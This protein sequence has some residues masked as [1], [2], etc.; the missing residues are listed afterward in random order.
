MIKKNMLLLLLL[1]SAQ[2][3][4]IMAETTSDETA[5]VVVAAESLSQVPVDADA[6]LTVDTTTPAPAIETTP[7]SEKKP[8][9]TLPTIDAAW[10]RTLQRSTLLFVAHNAL[11]KTYATV[12][13]K[14][15]ELPTLSEH[16]EATWKN[17]KNSLLRFL[18]DYLYIVAKYMID[19]KYEKTTDAT[20]NEIVEFIASEMVVV[21]EYELKKS[22]PTITDIA[23]NLRGGDADQV[24]FANIR[25]WFAEKETFKAKEFKLAPI[26][27]KALSRKQLWLPAELEITEFLKT[28][29]VRLVTTCGEKGV[30]TGDIQAAK[31]AAIGIG[32]E[33]VANDLLF[34]LAAR[35]QLPKFVV[36]LMATD[37]GF[38][39][40]RDLF[41]KALEDF[42]NKVIADIILA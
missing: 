24:T 14:I 26:F 17:K 19:T 33:K 1:V 22:T 41:A 42:A 21:K 5:T 6:Q 34:I 8:R 15:F 30:I 18:S 38:E 25:A 2:V 7:S 35:N 36:N 28:P 27:F 23:K 10:K 37:R 11:K 20:A 4:V 16:D 29:M 13:Y 40:V 12:T 3:P 31:F 32:S 9:F 39:L